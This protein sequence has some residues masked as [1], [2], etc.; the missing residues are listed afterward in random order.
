[1]RHS[2]SLLSV[3][4]VAAGALVAAGPAHAGEPAPDPAVA[5]LA[6]ER[7]VSVAEAEKRIGWQKRATELESALAGALGAEA[8]GGVWIGADDDRIKVGVVGTAATSARDVATS[9]KLGDAVDTT[10]VRYSLAA[11]RTANAALGASLATINAD[12]AWPLEGGYDPS[13]NTVHLGLPPKG[14]TLTAAQEAFV[15]DAQ[16]RLGGMLRTYSYT[17]RATADGCTFP[18]CDPPLRAGVRYNPTGCTL[19]FMGRRRSDNK[20]IAFTAGHCVSGLG[21]TVHSSRFADGVT[22]KTLG[23]TGANQWGSGG[24]MALVEIDDPNGWQVRNWVN[25]GASGSNGGVSG[26]VAKQDY[27]INGDSESVFG[28]RICRTGVGSGTS[29]GK[30]NGLGVTLTYG[31]VTVN[32]LGR[33]SYCRAGGDSG[34]PVYAENVAYGIHVAGSATCT[35]YYQGIHGAENALGADVSLN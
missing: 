16:A 29:C 32:D 33:A 14:G 20:F 23:V 9:L 27:R 28:M 18:Y 4:V 24:D 11:L 25:V 10:P 35:G 8:F 22:S 7:G 2:G 5:A 1:M 13:A 19:A 30:V 3:L 26:S 17:E 34:G 6:A 21:A 12:A 15:K 31:G